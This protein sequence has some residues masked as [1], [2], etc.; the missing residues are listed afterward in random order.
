MNWAWGYLTTRKKVEWVVR[1][2]VMGF[3]GMVTRRGEGEGE[4]E[5]EGEETHGSPEGASGAGTGGGW[6]T[7]GRA[8]F[9]PFAHPATNR[10]LNT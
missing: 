6:C 2:G 7:L 10:D 9:P 5:R 8:W 4:R 3:L 1:R